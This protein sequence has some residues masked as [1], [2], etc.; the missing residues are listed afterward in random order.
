VINKMLESYKTIIDEIET[1]IVKKKSKFICTLKHVKSEEEALD[2][3]QKMK[4]KYYDARHNCS[5][6]IIG[7]DYKL[8]RS[9]DDGEPSGTAGK[10]MLE[11]L[12][13][14][15]ITN[16]VAVV[17][18]YFGG[19]LL[20]TG[21]LIKAYTESVQSSLEV[22]QVYTYK[23]YEMVKIGIE[24]TQL[25]KMEFALRKAGQIIHQIDYSDS[26]TMTILFDMAMREKMKKQ[27]IEITSGKCKYS[28][29]GNCYSTVIKG[30]RDIV[31]QFI[32]N[33]K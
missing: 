13:G 24:Y 17:T 16:V 8:E 9:S 2:F 25:P 32:C 27:I 26:I 10:P 18:R 12:R 20:G 28:V 29:E 6:F 11:V 19:T 30:E 7:A 22:A 15:K 1:C 4:K 3:I 23:L 14:E 5:A 33:S 21:G 31:D